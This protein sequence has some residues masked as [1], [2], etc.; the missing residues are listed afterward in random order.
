MFVANLE[1]LSV[2]FSLFPHFLYSFLPTPI[3]C[4]YH[5]LIF[6]KVIL[7]TAILL[8]SVLCLHP[9]KLLSSYWC[10]WPLPHSWVTFGNLVYWVFW[11]TWGINIRLLFSCYCFQLCSYQP[12]FPLGCVF[13]NNI[14]VQFHNISGSLQWL[15]FSF[16]DSTYSFSNFSGLV[17][18]K[19]FS[20]L[21][22]A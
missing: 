1:S 21:P 13:L 4:L 17:G 11:K 22:L 8:T 6:T 20:F 16:Q 12:L 7:I 19:F 15:Y 14:L 18:S 5:L 10:N 2:I 3:L 9:L